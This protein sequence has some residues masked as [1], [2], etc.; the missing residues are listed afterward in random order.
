M[1]RL[2]GAGRGLVE[3]RRA[4]KD[5]IVYVDES[6]T[7]NDQR[8]M[9]FGGVMLTV[10][11]SHSLKASIAKWRLRKGIGSTEIKWTKVTPNRLWRFKEF[12]RGAL[13]HVRAGRMAFRCAVFDKRSLNFR[14]YYDSDKE[15]GY[16]MLMYQFLLNCFVK[17]VGEND[18]MFVYMDQRHTPYAL[19]DL[20]DILNAGIARKTGWRSVKIVRTVEPRDSKTCDFIQMADLLAGA[21]ASQN[22]DKIDLL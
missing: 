4:M 15:Q 2:G 3:R 9:A 13:H 14:K 18:R 22:N 10:E 20:V 5:W 16:Y 7:D 8:C 17:A 12:A 6:Y 21:V 11:E 19:G 1:S